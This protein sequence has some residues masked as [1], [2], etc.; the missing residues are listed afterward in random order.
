MSFT[1][2]RRNHEPDG[3]GIGYS[4]QSLPLDEPFN[5]IDSR[6]M[7]ADPD[8]LIHP[9]QAHRLQ[10]FRAPLLPDH[11]HRSWTGAKGRSRQTQLCNEQQARQ[12]SGKGPNFTSTNGPGQLFDS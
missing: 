12:H 9:A 10:R 3:C 5:D 7:Q 11:L 8:K 1:P 4:D 6:T 2:D